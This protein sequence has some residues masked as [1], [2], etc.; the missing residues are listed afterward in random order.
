M[1]GRMNTYLKEGKYV[2]TRGI[3]SIRDVRKEW[4]SF[5]GSVFFLSLPAVPHPPAPL[6]H[7]PPLA[8]CASSSQKPS[9]RTPPQI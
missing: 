8:R 5:A 9:R 7:P 1:Q 2:Q 3:G 4:V 6:P